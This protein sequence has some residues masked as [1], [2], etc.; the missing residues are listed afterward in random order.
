MKPLVFLHG[1]ACD[2][3]HFDVLRGALPERRTVALPWTEYV[4]DATP[5][6]AAVHA[7]IDRLANYLH[8]QRLTDAVLV[9]HSLGGALALLL[10]TR[11]DLQPSGL[12]LI[13]SSL[14]LST[15][16]K[17]AYIALGTSFLAPLEAEPGAGVQDAFARWATTSF[18]EKFFLPDDEPNM[19]ERIIQQVS[20]RPVAANA[21]TLVGTAQIDTSAALRQVNIPLLAVGSHRPFTSIEDLRALCPAVE[22]RQVSKGGHFVMFFA[23]DELSTFVREFLTNCIGQ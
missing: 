14:P 8:E 22:Y 20:H 13:D 7:L 17:K 5:P 6:A 18:R 11:S 12:I 4:D 9:G 2:T 16:R 15:E 21:K 10:A 19:V 3:D 1:F 23:P